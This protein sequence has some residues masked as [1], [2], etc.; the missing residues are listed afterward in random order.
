MTTKRA[1]ELTP[2]QELRLRAGVFAIIGAVWLVVGYGFLRT[3]SLGSIF[4]GRISVPLWQ[5]GL[6]PLVHGA[7]IAL[8]I[9]RPERWGWLATQRGVPIVY[10]GGVVVLLSLAS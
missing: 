1:L 3:W 4:D 7:A 10:G 2:E 8:A 5:C 6:L 9:R